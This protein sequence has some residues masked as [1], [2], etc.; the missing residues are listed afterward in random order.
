MPIKCSINLINCVIIKNKALPSLVEGNVT[1][2]IGVQ[3][4]DGKVTRL[5]LS[6]KTPP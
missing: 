5:E 1:Q 2:K 4:P 6:E 3:S